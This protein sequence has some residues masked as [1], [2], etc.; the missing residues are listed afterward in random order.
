MI[1]CIIFYPPRCGFKKKLTAY[2]Q[3]YTDRI[4]RKYPFAAITLCGD[5]NELDQKWLSAAL[6]LDQ[7]VRSLN[8]MVLMD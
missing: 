2:L 5:F 4:C 1:F 8:L 7:V 6:S 3:F